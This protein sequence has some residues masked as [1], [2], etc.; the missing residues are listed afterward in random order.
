MWTQER[1]PYDIMIHALRA[2]LEG[3]PPSKDDNL[4]RDGYRMALLDILE[5]I[6]AIR[7]K[8]AIAS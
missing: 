7:A 4:L 5:E 6:A 3:V 8:N 2:R 1:D